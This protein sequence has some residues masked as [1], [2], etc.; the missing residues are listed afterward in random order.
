[1]FYIYTGWKIVFSKLGFV[2][3]VISVRDLLCLNVRSSVVRE[4]QSTKRVDLSQCTNFVW[5][6]GV[7]GGVVSAVFHSNILVRAG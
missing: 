4:Y 2:S 3:V 1:M 7:G 5:R 6:G